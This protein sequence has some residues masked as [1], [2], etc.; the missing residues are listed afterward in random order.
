[1]SAKLAEG[2]APAR[3]P[4]EQKIRDSLHILAALGM[5]RAQLN[6]RSALTLLALL[7]LRPNGRWQ[8]LQPT[9]LGVTPIMSWCREHYQKAY[10]PNT[11]ETFRQQT[12]HQFLAN[13]L[14]F[15]NQDEP[16]RAVNSPHANYVVTPA[17]QALLAQFGTDAWPA[18]LETYLQGRPTLIQQYAQERAMTLLPLRI[19]AEIELKLSAGA[20]SS[21]L[22]AIIT[23]FAPRFA[24]E[25]E[26][27]YLGDTGPKTA[28][29]FQRE[30][31]A[32]LGVE[33]EKHG[34]MPDVVL[35]YAAKDWLLLIES[36]TSHGPVDGKRHQELRQLFAKHQTAGLVYVT[37]FP[38]KRTMGRYVGEIAWETEV[39]VAEAPTHLIHF[40]G[41]RFLGPYD[42]TP[43][44]S[45][46]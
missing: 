18:A 7:D 3:T 25:A 23:E 11:R 19:S 45:L 32:Q 28:D 1:M 22:A 36:V 5:P 14:V 2:E 16:T 15:Y 17:L 27:L 39:W 35:Y 6:E 30:R 43:S 4:A 33:I 42:T 8:A 46:A 13:G 9:P 20:H 10:A 44:T 38:D 40:N 41:V 37:A 34:K 12:L 29:Y 24:P 26:I 21:L 31:L